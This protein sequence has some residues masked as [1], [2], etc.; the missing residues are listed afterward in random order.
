MFRTRRL[1]HGDVCCLPM[2]RG[3]WFFGRVQT[4]TTTV[5]QPGDTTLER[6]APVAIRTHPNLLRPGICVVVVVVVVVDVA[7]GPC[8]IGARSVRALV[9]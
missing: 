1:I 2:P 4:Q 6:C 8:D 7:V 9:I 5:R 3:V